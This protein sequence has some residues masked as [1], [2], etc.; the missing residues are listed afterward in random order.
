MGMAACSSSAVN[1][2]GPGTPL[3]AADEPEFSGKPL[4]APLRRWPLPAWRPFPRMVAMPCWRLRTRRGCRWEPGRRE[5]RRLRRQR[6]FPGR[7]RALRRRLR[8]HRP[9]GRVD[10]NRGAEH[11][12]AVRARVDGRRSRASLPQSP[13]RHRR[14]AMGTLDPVE[15]RPGG[16]RPGTKLLDRG[17]DRRVLRGRL[18]PE[19]LRALLDV[20]APLDLLGTASDF[21]ADECSHVELASWM[22]M[23]SAARRRARSTSIASTPRPEPRPRFSAPTS[24]FSGWAASPRRS[25]G[26]R[27]R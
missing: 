19:V 13:S 10:T 9:R 6:G 11:E 14:F 21:L 4:H 17:R 24:S 5:P 23:E 2:L 18:L 7:H 16:G 1:G 20:K 15:V 25:A 26:G 27:P 8:C 12:S 22:A 3:D